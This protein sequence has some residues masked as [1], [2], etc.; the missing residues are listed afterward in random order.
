MFYGNSLHYKSTVDIEKSYNDFMIEYTNLNNIIES[1]D[2][3]SE[4]NILVE[5]DGPNLWERIRGLWKKFVKWVGDIFDKI[6]GIF[7]KANEKEAKKKI[8]NYF[9]NKAKEQSEDSEP[10]VL[11]LYKPTDNFKRSIEEYDSKLHKYCE[12]LS[13]FAGDL[14]FT[15]TYIKDLKFDT[16]YF[17]K[18]IAS[19]FDPYGGLNS[20]STNNDKCFNVVECDKEAAYKTFDDNKDLLKKINSASFWFK[21]QID[22]IDRGVDQEVN[23]KSDDGFHW[24]VSK[25]AK[26]FTF[27]VAKLRDCYK[28]IAVLS[29]VFNSAIKK[30][31]TSSS[32]ES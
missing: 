16:D 20:I 14:M 6:R 31:D 28:S 9:E 13:V 22:N 18:H 3:L 15:D 32:S 30:I 17:E 4:N 5:S 29:L 27:A 25:E 1:I 8:D 26:K 19:I 12:W 11:K 7:S 10:A 23:D 2:I 21:M 24:K